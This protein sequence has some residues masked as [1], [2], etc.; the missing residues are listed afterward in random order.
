M[1]I[2][3]FAVERYFARYEFTAQYMLSSSDC[4]GYPMNYV[5]DLASDS[6]KTS[7]DTLKLGYT[8]TL[9]SPTLRKAIKQHYKTI[10]LDDIVVSSPGEANFILMNILLNKGDHAI[11]MSPMY[12]SLYQIAKEL[13][14]SVSFWKP[15]EEQN[16]W[17]YNPADLKKLI[18]ANTKL[19]I[20]NFPHNP[21]GFSPEMNDY[22]EI[23]DIARH[24]GIP[25]FS[26]EM[27]RFLTHNE[28]SGLPP[29]CDLYENGISL[30]GTAKTFG[31]AGLRLG[32]LTSK[33]KEFLKKVESFKDYL[34]IC[35]SATSEILATI[36]LNNMDKFVQPNLQKIQSNIV[37]F[38]EFHKRNNHLFDFHKPKSGSTAFI[39]FKSNETSFQFA[40]KLVKETGIM[41]LPSETFEYGTSHARV[42]FGRANM[43]E[44]LDV[45]QKY[46]TKHYNS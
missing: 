1:N 13:E 26:D 30:W 7:W 10:D 44:M 29:M 11:C 45:F 24:Y 8:E 41:L 31:L 14:C 18:Q 32:W 25:I 39:K 20:I 37:L 22:L 40:E 36:A 28:H 23:I 33:N 6:E 9:G 4:D 42:G 16:K 19:I 15:T 34:S 27:Y 12:Q 35:N 21:T 43:P 5:L 17:H 3:D 46:I 38:S 2:K